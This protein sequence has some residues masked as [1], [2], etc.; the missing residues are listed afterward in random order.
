M[1]R[2]RRVRPPK[3]HPASS[4]TSTEPHGR[5]ASGRRSKPWLPPR[6]GP[7]QRPPPCINSNTQCPALPIG[8]G[9]RELPNPPLLNGGGGAAASGDSQRPLAGGETPGSGRAKHT[10]VCG[11]ASHPTT[12]VPSPGRL[13]CRKKFKASSSQPQ[14]PA[15]RGCFALCSAV[16]RWTIVGAIAGARLTS[17]L[18]PSSPTS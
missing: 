14:G 12:A 5:A 17:A 9:P 4:G 18:P 11:L 16:L 1:G 2:G 7:R 3:P 13:H 10:P 15:G 6:R 8:A